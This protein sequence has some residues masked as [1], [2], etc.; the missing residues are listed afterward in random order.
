MYGEPDLKCHTYGCDKD[1]SEIC[2]AC[3]RNVCDTHINFDCQMGLRPHRAMPDQAPDFV[4]QNFD[5]PDLMHDDDSED[6]AGP[7]VFHDLDGDAAPVEGTPTRPVGAVVPHTGPSAF[8]PPPPFLMVSPNAAGF[9]A[10]HA[11]PSVNCTAPHP[12]GQG[13]EM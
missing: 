10:P 9:V 8:A 1:L 4:M 7:M 13:T 3:G 2:A 5:E 12:I 11:A 6:H